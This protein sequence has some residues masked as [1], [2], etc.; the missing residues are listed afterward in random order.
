MKVF[1]DSDVIIAALLSNKGASSSLIN[2][3]VITGYVS[4]YSVEE[5]KTVIKRNNMDIVAL[6][7][8]LLKVDTIKIEEQISLVK[9]IYTSYVL[10]DNDAHIV[11]GAHLSKAE[12]LITFNLKHFNTNNIK[13][14][15]Q[16]TAMQPGPFLQ[17][18]RLLGKF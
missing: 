10:D 12:F 9:K 11:A 15:M 2:L 17:Y 4:N 1:F 18:L 5:L 6:N 13:N 7:K 3:A 8:L 14:D 16:I